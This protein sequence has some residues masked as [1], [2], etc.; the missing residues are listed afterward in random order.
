MS[1][2]FK[3]PAICN[4]TSRRVGTTIWRKYGIISEQLQKLFTSFLLLWICKRSIPYYR[5]LHIN[6]IGG[7]LCRAMIETVAGHNVH[8]FVSLSAPMMGQ[9]GRKLHN[10]CYVLISM[11]MYSL[12]LHTDNLPQLHCRSLVL[13][14]IHCIMHPAAMYYAVG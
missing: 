8:N 11:C 9:F 6:N 2:P 5:G 1:L 10:I 12:R 14:C 7:L 13:V 4:T 3:K